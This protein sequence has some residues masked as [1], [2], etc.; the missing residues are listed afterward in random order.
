MPVG[1]IDARPNPK[2]FGRRRDATWL[3]LVN[4]RG[5][6]LTGKVA[7]GTP[8]G[9]HTGSG[10]AA[11]AQ[12]DDAGM[13][14]GRVGAKVAEA[15]I[16]GDKDPVLAPNNHGDH[17]VNG[18]AQAL[19]GDGSD[20]MAGLGEHRGGPHVHVLVELEPHRSRSKTNS[21]RARAAP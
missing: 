5:I 10:L 3:N 12:H 14:A 20:V 11:Q 19:A 8:R 6:G 2:D 4:C 15:S 18:P 17:C 9:V 13:R 21:S 7:S 16:E 1:S